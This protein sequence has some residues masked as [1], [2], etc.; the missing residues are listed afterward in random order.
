M[1]TAEN[2]AADKHYS[3]FLVWWFEMGMEGM[4]MED[5]PPTGVVI[6]KDDVPVAGGFLFVTDSPVG[7]IGSVGYDTEMSGEDITSALGTLLMG[8][9]EKSKK[10]GL[11]NLTAM[12]SDTAFVALCA[13][14][15]FTEVDRSL[16]CL[17]KEI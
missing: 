14:M 11:K 10:A 7:L 6:L 12:A 9:I 4:D 3:A 13:S 1:L 17:T 2:F 5:L 15:G 8:L 16:T